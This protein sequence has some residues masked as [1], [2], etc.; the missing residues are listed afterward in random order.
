MESADYYAAFTTDAAI[1]GHGDVIDIATMSFEPNDTTVR[2]LLTVLGEAAS[3]GAHVTLAVDAYALLLEST[4]PIPGP[5][6]A[7]L[8]S[9]Q[10]LF[11]RRQQALDTLASHPTG[12]ATVINQPSRLFSSPVSGRNHIKISR[13]NDRVYLP[14]GNLNLTDDN[15]M[16]LAFTD[17]AA[18]DWLGNI[19]TDLANTGHTLDSLS[20]TDETFAVDEATELMVDAGIPGQSLIFD[21]AL[22]LIDDADEWLVL[23]TQYY[24]QKEVLQRLTRAVERNVAV[25]LPYNTPEAQGLL[26]KFPERVSMFR[27]RNVHPR[28]RDYPLPLTGR[29]MHLKG[30]ASEKQAIAGSHNFIERGVRSG[31]AELVLRRRD[32]SFARQVGD[33][34]LKQAGLPPLEDSGSGVMAA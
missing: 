16:V 25:Y 32:A 20:H 10:A 9:G 26:E 34:M 27:S 12:Q 24:P 5:L 14:N 30:L 33:F 18:A 28:L 1:S 21:E 23:A 17:R 19:V 11:H 15:D 6:W 22:T 2:Q 3:R 13:H 7:P 8:P 31:T 29:K 4:H